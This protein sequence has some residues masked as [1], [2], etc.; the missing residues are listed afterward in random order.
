MKIRCTY[1]RRSKFLNVL[2][3]L[4]LLSDCSLICILVLY[5]DHTI[6][7]TLGQFNLFFILVLPHLYSDETGN[8]VGYHGLQRTRMLVSTDR[9]KWFGSSLKYDIRIYR[10]P[11][12]VFNRAQTARGNLKGIF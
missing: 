6:C 9:G 3:R 2:R 5:V 11:E 12:H 7:W 4:F 10:R 1:C 8:I